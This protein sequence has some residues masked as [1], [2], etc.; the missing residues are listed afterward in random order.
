MTTLPLKAIVKNN[1]ITAL[2][3]FQDI[4][5]IPIKNLEYS[6]IKI[7]DEIV[8]LGNNIILSDSVIR[9]SDD[10]NST[11]LSSAATANAVKTAYDFAN[12]KLNLSGGNVTGNVSVSGNLQVSNSKFIANTVMITDSNNIIDRVSGANT[13][14]ISTRKI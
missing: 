8:D 3:Q 7:N 5:K 6:Y 1:K 10:I 4:D 14:N 9:L 2:G 13:C 12:T 11:S